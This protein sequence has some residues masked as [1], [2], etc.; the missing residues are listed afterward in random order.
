MLATTQKT[1][2]AFRA[3]VKRMGHYQE[4][5]SLMQWDLRTGAP[6]KGMELR[7]EALGTLAAE[8]FRMATSTELETY[9]E[10]L[11]RPE[12]QETLEDTNRVLV[13]KLKKDFDRSRKIP[14]ARFEAFVV[15]CSQAESVWEEAKHSNNFELFRPY[16]EQIVAMNIEFVGYWGHAEN[17]YDTL[18]NQYEPGLT[19]AQLD[20]IF[21]GLRDET[22][23]LL[24]AIVDSG[25]NPDVS[26]LTQT[27]DKELQHQLSRKVLEQMGY[28]FSAGR[29]D[30][31]VHPFETTIN[32]YDVR[33]TTMYV[34]NDIRSSLF[35]TIHEGGHALYEQGVSPELIGTPLCEGSS[36]GIHESQSRFWENMIGRSREFWEANYAD[37]T[38][39]FPTQLKGVSVDAFYRA[40]N[41][42]EPSL[43]RIEADELTYN[44][45]IMIRYEIEKGLINGTLAVKD[46]P[47]IWKQLMHDYLGVTPATDAEGVLQ[48][49]H[50]AGGDF[51][52][53]PTYALG[54]IYA[55]QFRHTLAQQMPDYMDQVHRGETA[56]IRL[57]LNDNIHHYGK[58]LS[59]GE[60]VRKVTGEDI[61][62]EYLV[63]YLR[64]K[65]TPL[66]QL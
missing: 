51:G 44:L 11:N 61:N 1:V 4:A 19:V 64:D 35:S 37:L 40:V 10:E 48:D 66:Y 60:I 42:V 56:K 32:R 28:D 46:L 3:Y 38:T 47:A 43:I 17:K 29:L 13:K 12:V 57:W 54:N 52:Y 63:A 55:A 31:T 45:H 5:V 23:K 41:K 33:V 15:L 27:Y 25:V 24:K 58:L 14:H 16:L 9:L 18:L 2:S 62:S 7:S 53:F 65:F 39:L 30:E 21:S 49:V 20:P 6:K 59:P 50:W 26:F 36:M 22:V 34:A 8:A